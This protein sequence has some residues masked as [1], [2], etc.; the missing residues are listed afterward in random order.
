MSHHT[1]IRLEDVTLK[2][3]EKSSNKLILDR[4]SFSVSAGKITTVLGPSGSG[5]TLVLRL[6]NR[7]DDPTSGRILLGGT[8]ISEIPI[9]QLRR[10]VGMVFQIPVMFEGTV[11]KNL[12]MTR[13]I[14][15]DRKCLEIDG[16]LSLVDLAEEYLDREA[17]NLSVGEQQRVQLAR[18]LISQPEVLLLDEPTSGL[19]VVTSERIIELIRRIN[20]GT[21]TTVVFVTHILE[22]ARAL[23]D[24]VALIVE[25]KI[26]RESP[27]KDFF[28]ATPKE[29]TALFGGK[30]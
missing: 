17:A 4:V 23:A 18:T 22:Q 1:T 28:K 15:A 25:G 24:H 21:G 27:A 26:E 5:K 10:R 8:D 3:P 16:L 9:S 30:K 13:K 19:D 2:A 14:C 12:E 29:L 20:K 6:L 7:L 11:R